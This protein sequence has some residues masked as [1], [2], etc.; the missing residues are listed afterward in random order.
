MYQRILVPLDGSKLAECVLPHVEA[1]A[2]GCGVAD[3]I[4]I[5]VAEGV[6]VPIATEP[7][8][9]AEEW[10]RI[11]SEHKATAENYLKQLVSQL[12]WSGVNKQIEVPFGKPADRIADYAT[13]NKVD[14]IVIATHGRTGVSRWVLGSVADRVTRSACVPVLIVRPPECVPGI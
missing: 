11:E 3:V 14:L 10:K 9:T 2:K 7:G 12:K 1:I 13:E 8:L 6:G 5:R 4:F